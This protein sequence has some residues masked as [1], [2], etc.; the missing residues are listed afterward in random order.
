[1]PERNSYSAVA[2]HG[3]DNALFYEKLFFI[4]VSYL[5]KYVCSAQYSFFLDFV[6]MLSRYVAEVFSE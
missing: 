6:D 3:T 2:V 5:P 1:M 4:C